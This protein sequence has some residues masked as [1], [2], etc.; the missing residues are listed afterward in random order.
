MKDNPRIYVQPQSI[1][2]E[3]QSAPAQNRFAFAYIITIHNLDRFD[4][5]LLR[6]YWL[7]TNA[8]GKKL[9]V[10]GEGVVGEQPIITPNNRY[11]YTSGTLLETPIGTMQGYYEM[12]GR[13]DVLFRV[14]IP[15]FRLAVPNLVH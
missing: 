15:A 1:Y 11:Q 4:V 13:N 8:N 2:V 5:Q 3:A 9:E 10:H 12:K 6:R 7:I 14:E